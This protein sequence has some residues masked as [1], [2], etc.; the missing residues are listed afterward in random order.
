[1]TDREQRQV[2][3]QNLNHLISLI[4]KQQQ[5]VAND[6]DIPHTTFNTWCVGKVIPSVPTLHMLADYFNCSI[7]DL[8]DPHD[9]NFEYRYQIVR[10]FRKHNEKKY[11][12]MVLNYLQFLE[13]SPDTWK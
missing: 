2:F 3:G 8:I 13:S 10:T 4:G 6:L 12:Q 5:E 7:L 9:E 1:M 11:M